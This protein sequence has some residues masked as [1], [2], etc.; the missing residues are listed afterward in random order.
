M[1]KPDYLDLGKYI[2]QEGVI[3]N[4]RVSLLIPKTQKEYPDFGKGHCVCCG[5]DLPP[6][7]RKYC[8]DK[9]GEEYRRETYP[10]WVYF[11]TNFRRAIIKRDNYKCLE[12]GFQRVFESEHPRAGQG[13]ELEGDFEVHHIVPIHCGGKEFDPENCRTLCPECHIEEHRYRKLEGTG[14]KQTKLEIMEAP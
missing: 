5:K 13:W 14:I 9:C 6:M 2:D 3:T 10:Y 4:S 7:R 11:W 1:E 8:S 12:C